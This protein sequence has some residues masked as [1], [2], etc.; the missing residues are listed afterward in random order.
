MVHSQY[1]KAF[2]WLTPC[3]SD[4]QHKVVK[5]VKG[6][7]LFLKAQIN[8]II[9]MTVVPLQKIFKI[10]RI[11]KT[12]N[13]NDLLVRISVGTYNGYLRFMIFLH[14]F[15][16]HFIWASIH[17]TDIRG[18]VVGRDRCSVA[19][20]HICDIFAAAEMGWDE[21]RKNKMIR[22]PV[23]HAW[24]SSSTRRKNEQNILCQV[25]KKRREYFNSFQLECVT[26]GVGRKSW[27]KVV[28]VV[29]DDDGM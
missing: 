29:S 3:Q 1:R 25:K 20:V 10:F 21:V 7:L 17:S 5:F 15:N 24:L 19:L 12:S 23:Y 13:I 28:N 11:F 2:P 6:I 26:D 16:K 9:I 14:D 8:L 18:G 22:S 4:H 27:R